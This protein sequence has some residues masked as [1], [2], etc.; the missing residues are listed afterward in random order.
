MCLFFLLLYVKDSASSGCLEKWL[1]KVGDTIKVGDTLC[2]VSVGD[3][4]V[5]V[6]S[7]Y[8]GVLAVMNV[9]EG[10]ENVPCGS[11]IAFC[12]NDK[13]EY[14]K[15]LE[16]ELRQAKKSDKNSNIDKKMENVVAPSPTTESVTK[17]EKAEE[18]DVAVPT[19]K[20]ATIKDVLRE[21]K[22]L[23]N[24]GTIEE[25][26]GMCPFAINAIIVFYVIRIILGCVYI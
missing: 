8:K 7:D 24:N 3:L 15:Y 11:D 25:E 20:V 9:D 14:L 22:Y 2:H 18:K 19:E 16:N 5:G 23:I 1:V 26:S 13:D 4:I 21:I 6:D 10:S 17:T 12:V